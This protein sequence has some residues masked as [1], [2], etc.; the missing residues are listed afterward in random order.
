MKTYAIPAFV[1]LLM[2][3]LSGAPAL[4]GDPAPPPAPPRAKE[5][6]GC[7]A[8]EAM[9]VWKLTEAKENDKTEQARA[10]ER[11][12]AN[13]RAWCAHGDIKAKA[14][15]DIWEKEQ[16]VAE[17]EKNL[18]DARTGGKP[19]KIAKRERKLEEA[20]RALEDARRASG[21]TRR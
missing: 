20:R 8:K 14:E 12:L 21:A 9:L 15:L 11:A 3:V 17:C 19:E 13:T 4:G 18:R 6:K 7:R 1:A 16:D 2:L 5:P 10:L